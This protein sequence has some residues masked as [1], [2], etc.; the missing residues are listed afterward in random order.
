[1]QRARGFWAVVA[2]AAAFGAG[3]AAT[4]TL[5]PT[6][7]TALF[8]FLPDYNFGGQEDLPAGTLGGAA[9]FRRSRLLLK[10]DLAAGLPPD[11]RIQAARLR[12]T[13]TRVPDGGG[14]NSIFGL[15][16][17]LRAWG[18]GRQQGPP[19]G[20]AKAAV[21]EASWNFRRFPDDPWAAPGGQPGIDFAASPGS[22]ERILQHGTYEFEFGANQIAELQAWLHAP[23]TNFGWMLLSQSETEPKT[24]RRFAAR[25]HPVAESRPAL[26]L[27]YTLDPPLSP[28]RIAAL[29]LV[30]GKAEIRFAAQAGITY[31]LISRTS[32]ATGQ[33]APAA[34][35][36]LAEVDGELT[37]V[38]DS[39]LAVQRFYRLQARR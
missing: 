1:M 33:W 11:A 37:L 9:G 6:A 14:A 27:E 18:E 34:G 26:I 39:V 16:R 28:P 4:I 22:S 25:E 36:R 13:V 19:P 12:L 8:E 10:F 5:T 32:A 29:R 20:G 23:E 35:P 17:V 21:G 31:T 7:D 3:H 38:D 2:W 30:D 24:A 15:H